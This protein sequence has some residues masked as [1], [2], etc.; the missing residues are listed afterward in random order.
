MHQKRG[1]IN[2]TRK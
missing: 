2:L 1:L